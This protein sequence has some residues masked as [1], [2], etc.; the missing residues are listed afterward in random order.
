MLRNSLVSWRLGNTRCCLRT[1]C[2]ISIN[3]D[4]FGDFLMLR[5]GVGCFQRKRKL[6]LGGLMFDKTLGK[7]SGANCISVSTPHLEILTVNWKFWFP[8]DLRFGPQ[9]YRDIIMGQGVSQT[10]AFG[11]DE[12]KDS[13]GVSVEKFKS[14]R[15]EEDANEDNAT[16]NSSF[17]LE[18]DPMLEQEDSKLESSRGSRT[19]NLGPNPNVV[20]NVNATMAAPEEE[21]TRI[22]DIKLETGIVKDGAKDDNEDAVSET[23][24][25]ASTV[26]DELGEPPERP[27][28]DDCCGQGCEPCVWDTY[29]DELR[30]YLA[31][32][33][34]LQ[35]GK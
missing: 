23:I 5:R 27:L 10:R 12:D 16:I 17:N 3:V 1:G 2:G 21:L 8:P 20:E 14:S 22:S 13:K 26:E 24:E 30:D 18:S 35:K 32:K 19:D 33:K 9:A 4:P 7:S 31:R 25:K 29:N 11:V 6:I 15:H 34:A 28:P